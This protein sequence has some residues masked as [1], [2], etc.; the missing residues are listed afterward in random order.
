MGDDEARLAAI[1]ALHERYVEELIE[2]WN[3]CPFA[4]RARHEGRVHRVW[5]EVPRDPQDAPISVWAAAL[6]RRV[7]AH[8]EVEIVLLTFPVDAGHAWLDPRAFEQVRRE[9][10]SAYVRELAPTFHMVCFHPTPVPA[11]ADTPETLIRELRR[12]PDPV[13]QCV[14]ASVLDELHATS[15]A[16][17][18]Q[19]RFDEIERMFGGALTEAMRD[20]V[21]H[22]E[23]ENALSRNIAE[24]NFEVAGEGEGR[25]AL[26]ALLGALWSARRALDS[27]QRPGQE[28]GQE[29]GED[30]DGGEGS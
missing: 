4:R 21:F 5:H 7:R 6:A 10:H 17:A 8:E 24:R 28:R 27:E 1:K 22:S 29:E 15:N 20:V 25:E 26:E 23:M 30:A 2:G 3:V 12:T 18:R 11:T 16:R 9:L 19:E 13:I 14:R